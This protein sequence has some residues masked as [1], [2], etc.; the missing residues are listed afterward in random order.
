MGKVGLWQLL[1][2]DF[3]REEDALL[4]TW[5]ILASFLRYEYFLRKS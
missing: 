2:G 1:M 4:E 3:V 5:R